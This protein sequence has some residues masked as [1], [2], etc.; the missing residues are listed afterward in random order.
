MNLLR[1]ANK[2]KPSLLVVDMGQAIA[3]RFAAEGAEIMLIG[4]RQTP[5]DETSAAIEQEGGCAWAYPAE[6]SKLDQVRGIVDAAMARWGRIDILVNNAGVAGEESVPPEVIDDMLYSFE[7]V[8]MRH[9][10]KP[11]EVAAAFAFLAS[12][13]A[14]AITGTN[15]IVD[16]GLAADLYILNTLPGS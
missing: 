9:L 7:R 3:H 4:R 1:L 13:D 2:R 6:V 12:D 10:V 11:E 16:C 15:L 14:S 8:P 5:L